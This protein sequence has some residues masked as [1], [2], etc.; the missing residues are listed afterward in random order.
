MSSP[1]KHI[2][3]VLCRVT[4]ADRSALVFEKMGFTTTPLSVIEPMGIAN[5]LI[6]FPQPSPDCLNFI[7]LM[8][9]VSPTNIHPVMAELLSSPDGIKSMVLSGPNAYAAQSAFNSAGFDFDP[10]TEVAREWTL[11]TGEIIMPAFSVLLPTVRSLRF[12]YCHYRNLAPYVRPEWMTHPNGI[13]K[14]SAV[15][16]VSR[17]PEEAIAPFAKLFDCPTRLS[18]DGFH[19][20]TPGDVLL[21][22]G[23]AKMASEM[24]GEE[25]DSP[26]KFIGIELQTPNL[27]HTKAFLQS[28]EVPLVESEFG[29]TINSAHAE[30]LALAVT[31]AL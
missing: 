11:P 12:N 28:A 3:H 15:I 7:E 17:D 13:N 5:R 4:S 29:L 19:T 20:A 8:A 18:A 31:A 30:G 9:V 14:L 24:F 2:D 27:S 16:A 22:I 10:P 26:E 21:K 25:I 23:T 6:L 1:I